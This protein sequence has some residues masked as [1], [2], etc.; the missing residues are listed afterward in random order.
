MDK[1]RQRL[2]TTLLGL[3][4]VCVGNVLLMAEPTDAIHRLF[5]IFFAVLAFGFLVLVGFMVRA[6]D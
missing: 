4:A 6:K 1:S 2:I 5:A 3:I